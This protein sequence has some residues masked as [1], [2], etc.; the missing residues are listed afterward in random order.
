[1]DN[2]SIVAKVEED[3][4]DCEAAEKDIPVKRGASVL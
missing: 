4:A 2:V 1:V 3:V